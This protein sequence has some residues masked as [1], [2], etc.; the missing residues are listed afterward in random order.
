MTL[1]T[2][3]GVYLGEILQPTDRAPLWGSI[4]PRDSAHPED[5]LSSYSAFYKE[6]LDSVDGDKA[7]EALFAAENRKAN[8]YF[9]T[10][11]G[12]F[13][14]AYV[15]YLLTDCTEKG[16]WTRAQSMR[17]QL[18]Q[19]GA[20][21]PSTQELAA[22]LKATERQSFEKYA[23]NFFMADLYPENST[24]FSIIYDDVYNEVRGYR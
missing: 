6:L 21:A 2:C 5:K 17:A 22:K 24:R 20:K 14:K 1:A 10:A 12:M 3:C 11:E 7:S 23:H 19:N 15:K 18:T 8:Y 16:Y 4:G 9:V 13:R